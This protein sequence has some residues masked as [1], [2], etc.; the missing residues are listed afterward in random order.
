[1]NTS[2]HWARLSAAMAVVALLGAC[3]TPPKPYDYT[4][5]KASS[6]KTLLV[7]PPVSE[8]PDVRAS[9]SV[10]A[11][12]TIPLAE[13]GYYVLP[14]TLV[15]ETFR[16][17][18]LTSPADIQAV[19]KAKLREI[20]GADAAV[21]INVKRYGTSYNVVSGDAVVT[22]QGRLVDLNSGALLWEGAATASSA[23]GGSN[24]GGLAGLLI[25]AIVSQILNSATDASFKVAAVA[26]QRLLSSRAVNGILPGPRLVTPGK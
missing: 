6:P 18:G 8:S 22:I 26:D 24:Q 19:D 11:Q 16:E 15:D 20:F 9:I 25:K 23:E 21:Y 5:F 3:A 13:S 14:V 10:M 7:L 1:M 2:F 4:A 12:A 17:N